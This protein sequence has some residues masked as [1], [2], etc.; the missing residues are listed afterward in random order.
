MNC[1]DYAHE[2]L[3]GASFSRYGIDA[4]FGPRAR[5]FTDYCRRLVLTDGIPPARLRLLFN[6]SGARIRIGQ[7]VIDGA[8]SLGVSLSDIEPDRYLSLM[9]PPYLP[10]VH[11]STRTEAVLGLLQLVSWLPEINTFSLEVAGSALSHFI[12]V[13]RNELPELDDLVSELVLAGILTIDTQHLGAYSIPPLIQSSARRCRVRGVSRTSEA[14]SALRITMKDIFQA[15]HQ[16]DDVGLNEILPLAAALEA[17]TVLETIWTSHSA[18]LFLDDLRTGIEAYLSVPDNVL[19]A[20]PILAVAHVFAKQVKTTSQ[21]LDSTDP[22]TVLPSATFDNVFSSGLEQHASELN[23]GKFSPN[24]VAVLTVQAA[25]KKR[26]EGAHSDALKTV[27]AGRDYL[28]NRQ[29]ASGWPSPLQITELDYEHALILGRI[30]RFSDSLVLLQRIIRTTEAEAPRTPFPLQSVHVTAAQTCLLLGVHKEA[31]GHLAQAQAL[32][33]KTGFMT[34]LARYSATTVELYRS[35]DELDLDSAKHLLET[36]RAEKT[37]FDSAAALFLAEG[38]YDVY[39]GR[40]SLAVKQF[41]E[42]HSV[43]PAWTRDRTL[44]RDSSRINVLSFVCLAAGETKPIQQLLTQVPPT[45]P[46]FGLAKAR[47]SLA[48]G[49]IEEI[50][51]F[52]PQILTSD[53]GPRLKACGHGLR[54][55]GLLMHTRTTEAV[56]E[57]TTVLE[58]CVVSSTLMPIAQLPRR[59][60]ATLVNATAANPTWTLLA[61]SFARSGV[62]ARRRLS[63]SV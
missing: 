17:W 42:G 14:K 30:G 8:R 31:D 1:T 56:T 32:A 35:L 4:V 9:S 54:A 10:P 27:E 41:L 62:E 43:P 22:T 53:A 55:A 48:L 51:G 45:I 61:R 21:T 12:E 28:T 34:R 25:R 20:R 37:G 52:V 57:F 36:A 26:L 60:R 59:L 18:N 47:L 23:V 50:F 11:E 2:K 5:D 6:A 38:L 19:N 3:E 33:H 16:R 39:S 49:Q 13:D 46:G 40:A 58:Y 29:A 24:E 15:A 63:N 7:A 44:T